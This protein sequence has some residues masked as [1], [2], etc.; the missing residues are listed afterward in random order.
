MRSDSVVVLAP[1]RD[2]DLCFLQTVEDFAVKQLIGPA[3]FQVILSQRLVQKS[4]VRS[5]KISFD[6]HFTFGR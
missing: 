6:A 3:P 1:L 5:P 4:Q 2:D